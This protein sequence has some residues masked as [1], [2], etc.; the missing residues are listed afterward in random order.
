M[1]DPALAGRPLPW[2]LPPPLPEVV[3]VFLLLVPLRDLLRARPRLARER[4]SGSSR[5]SASMRAR[6]SV[7]PRVPQAVPSENVESPKD[8]PVWERSAAAEPARRA[9]RAG[10]RPR[11]A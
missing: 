10:A 3:G 11:T 4:T 6:G 8:V 9:A 5:A 2:M 1:L 7:V